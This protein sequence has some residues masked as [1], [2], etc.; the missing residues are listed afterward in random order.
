MGRSMDGNMFLAARPIR[1]RMSR[2]ADDGA[3]PDGG[4]GHPARQPTTDETRYRPVFASQSGSPTLRAIW[5][6]AYG[7]DYPE[8]LEP[9]SFIT[10]SGLNRICAWLGVGPGDAIVDIGCGRGGPGLWLAR[11]TGA[12]L[13]GVDIAPEAVAEA[14]RFAARFGM[15]ERAR[16]QVGSFTATGLAD[17][18][19]QGAVSIDSLWMVLDKPAAVREVGRLLVPGA[20]WVC[21][22]WEPSYFRY[23]RVLED[24][25]WVV[26]HCHEP[27]EW[28]S[29]QVA[30]YEGI[31]G[32]QDRLIEELGPE[33]AQV[34]IA[35]A[36]DIA[37][38]L[39]QYRRLFVVARR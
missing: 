32:E 29:R 39:G 38:V 30:V 3:P 22:T 12:S 25:G 1:R 24:A 37:P 34:L 5:R 23:R 11:E 4:D 36:R 27:T 28:Q 10:R 7:P 16:F 35:E 9:L 18:G 14:R 26:L 17:E 6:Q 31:L 21:T 2:F 15:A 20:R 8:E 33:A 13:L 19:F